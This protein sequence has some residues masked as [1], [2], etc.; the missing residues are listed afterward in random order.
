M[1]MKWSVAL[2]IAATGLAHGQ[3]GVT[4]YGIVDTGVSYY[5]HATA[6]GGTSI[7]M[8]SLTGRLP[9]RW[10]V[11]GIEE[12]GGGFKTFFVLEDGFQPGN[13]SLN[14]GGRLFGIQANVG[15]SSDYG[16]FTLGRQF[17]MTMYAL[18]NADVIGPSV[19]SLS[20]FDSYLPNARSDNA[21]GYLGKF[22]GFTAGGTYS[23]GR[24]AAGPA[25]PSATNCPGQ[26]PGNLLACRQYTALLAYDSA[27]FGVAV[28]YDVLRGGSGA[29]APLNSSAYT[30]THNI[31]DGYVSVG[32]TKIGLG[33]IRNNLAAA[34]HLQTDI[35]FAGATYFL[36]PA[37]FFDAQGVRF[38]Q[39]GT[40]GAKDASSTLLIGRANYLF[41]KRSMVYASVGYM[42]NST[43]AASAVAAGGTVATGANQLGV[44]IGLQQK[45]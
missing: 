39:R 20:V 42:F 11:R 18:M 22:A 35:F 33:W 8:A 43:Q 34:T 28:S 45:F 1:K 12:L 32:A 3:S 15:I 21:V 2:L 13:G 6:N 19:H 26:V 38:L 9:S 24:D 5:N 17:G 7:G 4:L 40:Q 30:D 23:L 31:V 44:V 41:S 36:T 37:I 16:S 27:S 14:Y 10:G 25:G 29:S